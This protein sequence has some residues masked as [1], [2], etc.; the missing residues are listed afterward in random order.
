VKASADTV[1]AR[2]REKKALSKLP[3]EKEKVKE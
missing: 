2:R 3:E 1:S